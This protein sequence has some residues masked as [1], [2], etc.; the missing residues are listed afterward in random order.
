MNYKELNKCVKNQEIS[1]VY[2]FTGPEQYIG[3]MMEKT[4][5]GTE[6]AK[7]LEPLNLTTYSDKNLDISELLATCET[8]P[9]MSNKRMVIVREEAQLDKISDK[10]DL[11][12][13]A[14]Y[15][16]KPCP[17]T[18][19]IIYWEQPDKR[20]KLYKNL[21]KAGSLVVFEKLDASDLQA[22]IIRRVKNA[23]KKINRAELELFI[24]RSMYL[25]N[26]KKT[27]E[28]VDNELN[29]LIDYT[30]DRNEISKEDIL[31]IL[32]QSIEEGIFKLIDYAVSGQ[33]DQALLMLN[34]FYLEGESP[35]GVFSLLL[36][37]IRMLLM[38]KIYSSRGLP[39][40]TVAV[41]MKL[42]PFIVNKILKNGKNYPIDNLWEIMV[43]GADL[44]AQ[45]KLGEIDQNF[46][47]ELFLMKIR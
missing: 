20:K 19:L 12:R 29:S 13:I 23:E 46:A 47:L 39:A 32:P 18:L 45:M 24:S 28:M 25:I 11:D 41:E 16:E 44:D 40:K 1:P 37:Q 6:L 5:I 15:L 30:G 31:L 26:E 22:W 27:M 38:V 9:M 8:L 21:T 14:A 3:H 4:L 43:I 10:K 36:R 34:H 35:F 42:A 7:G 2:L 33:K 17:S